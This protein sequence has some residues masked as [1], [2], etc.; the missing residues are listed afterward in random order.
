MFPTFTGNSR[1]PRNVNL[2]GQKNINP[3]ASGTSKSSVA[4]ADAAAERRQRQQERE[5]K[6]AA[7]RIQR[8][9]RGHKVRRELSSSYRARFDQLY[10]GDAIAG[11]LSMTQR[12]P[13]G[14]ALLLSVFQPELLG[15]LRRLARVSMDL[16]TALADDM[17][18]QSLYTP[19]RMNAL[20]SALLEALQW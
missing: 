16:D 2:S 18:V 20:V 15:D 19:W 4:V 7:Q 12:L 8:T 9:W 1:R 17:L 3:F 6:Q 14:L 10:P 5:R 13:E 11:D